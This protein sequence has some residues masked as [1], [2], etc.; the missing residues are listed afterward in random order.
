VALFTSIFFGFMPM[1]LFA[2]FVY[3]LDRYEKEPKILL[4]A[5]FTW[6]AL[7]AAGLSFLLNTSVGVGLYLLTGSETAAEITSSTLTAPIIEE[8]FKGLAVLL[9]FLIFH[10]EFDSILDG[11]IYAA[12]TAL[13][14][15]AT[16][17]AFYI[18]SYGYQQDG[19][20]GI[21]ALTIIRVLIVGWQHPFYTSFTGIG[22]AAARLSKS[23][24]VKI[25]A[26]LAGL[27]AAVFTHSA[28]NLI[29]S[30]V[31]GLGGFVFGSLLDWLGWALMFAFVLYRIYAE[32][33]LLVHHL[34]EEIALGILTA[35][36]YQTAC[37]PW[38]RT[39]AQINALF[40][41]RYT[42]TRRFYRLCGELAHKKYQL[43]S[44]GDEQGNL[45]IIHRLRAEMQSLSPNAAA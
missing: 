6:G 32:R 17:N 1:L 45:E 3:W 19:W 12:V 26:P 13:G 23:S 25:L 7:V 5:A 43:A 15:A 42:A 24:T 22:L 8:I 14:F 31:P 41:G 9:V 10:N 36:Q 37:S 44:L 39:T 2:V 20:S 35:P 34:Q 16:E 29:A 28:H 30:V 27:T 4:G 18:Y 11:L 38:S 40:N 21:F 33:R